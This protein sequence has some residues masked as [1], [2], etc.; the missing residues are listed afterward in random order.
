MTKIKLHLKRF[1]QNSHPVGTK[2]MAK[3]FRRGISVII[4]CERK[5][6]PREDL[7]IQHKDSSSKIKAYQKEDYKWQ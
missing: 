1:S 2:L 4:G 6:N 3:L 7:N 5:R